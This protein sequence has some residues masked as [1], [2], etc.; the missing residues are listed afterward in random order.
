V[1]H[2]RAQGRT[3][4]HRVAGRNRE[5]ELIAPPGELTLHDLGDGVEARV[6]QVGD[7]QSDE[8]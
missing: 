2:Q 3:L 7:D 4:L 6:D 1:I 5:H 8:L